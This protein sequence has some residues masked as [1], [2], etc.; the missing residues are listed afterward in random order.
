MAGYNDGIGNS[1]AAHNAVVADDRFALIDAGDADV[2]RSSVVSMV[3][4]WAFGADLLL[5]PGF[6]DRPR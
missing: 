4:R 2:R 5:G 3:H 1:A 6:C